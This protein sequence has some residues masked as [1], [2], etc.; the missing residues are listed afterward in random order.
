MKKIGLIPCRLN[1]TRLP[2]KPLKII[3]DLPMFAHVYFRSKLSDLDAVYICTDST[4]I[5]LI[6]KSLEINCIMTS[7][8]HTNGTERCAEAAQK[9]GLS[10][11]DLVIDIQGDEPMVSPS[12]INAVLKEFLNKKCD[13]I[14]PFLYCEDFNKPNIVKILATVDNKIL[15]MSRGDI[16]YFFR[17]NEPLKKHL[18]IIAFTYNTIAKFCSYHPS[19]HEIIEGIELLRAVENSMD[20]QTMELEGETRAVDTYEDLVYVREEMPYDPWLK[21][22]QDAKK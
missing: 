12:H 1:S 14:V 6:A 22:Y 3:E 13:I 7:I 17:N 15:Y 8:T 19:K 16:P 4:E 5:E 21:I 18:S 2:N 11:N 20:I 9:L 10:K